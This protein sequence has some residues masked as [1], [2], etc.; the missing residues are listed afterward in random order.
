[1]SFV[2]RRLG[3]YL[4]AFFVAATINFAIPRLMPGD[5]VAIMF[6]HNERLPPESL[7]SLRKTFGFVDGPLIV[8]YLAYLKSVVTGD[9]GLS[10]K[11]FPTP[12]TLVLA[13]ALSW[14]L[15]LVGGATLLSFM[16]G[17][18]LGAAAAWRRGGPFDTVVSTLGVIMNALP[19][20]VLAL[21]IL[22]VFGITLRWLPTGYAYDPALDP[23][24]DATFIG[25]VLAHAVMPV[26]ALSL[27]LTGGFLINMRNNMINLLGDDYLVMAEAKGLSPRRVMLSY[28]FR[29]ALLPTVTNLAITIGQV[30]AGSLVTEVVFNYPGVGNTLY[31][32][33]LARDYP[34][35]QGQ[36]LVMTLAMLA[37]NFIADVSYVLIDP[38]L[39]RT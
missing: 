24:L 15:V 6:A 31:V 8:Q 18:L 29:N 35:I 25:S 23:G 3:F 1:M 12:V 38:R 36:L 9:L 7:A 28:G 34:L 21:L 14:T 11:F 37:A 39:R 19:A 30:F 20:V 22:F 32:A 13:H 26:T 16:L 4:I 10:I 17:T 33:I 27:V 2:L 5:P